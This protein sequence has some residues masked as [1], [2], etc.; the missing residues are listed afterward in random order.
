M[1][2]VVA[3][4]AIGLCFPLSIV[5]IQSV[6]FLTQYA[7]GYTEKRFSKIGAG[8]RSADVLKTAGEPLLRYRNSYDNSEY[9]RYTAH[10]GRKLAMFKMRTV[11]FSNDVVVDVYKLNGSD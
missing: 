10:G 11:R 4:I 1:K 2:R 7:P 8:M 5:L 9:W 3:V 6:V